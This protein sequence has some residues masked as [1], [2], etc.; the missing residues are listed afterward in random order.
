MENISIVHVLTKCL[1]RMLGQ[2]MLIHPWLCFN[3]YWWINW[4]FWKS[5]EVISHPPLTSLLS[6][7]LRLNLRTHLL[8]HAPVEGNARERQGRRCGCRSAVWQS[9][10]S[11]SS[12]VFPF[13]NCIVVVCEHI[14]QTLYLLNCQ[15]LQHVFQTCVSE[16]NWRACSHRDPLI[17]LFVFFVRHMNQMMKVYFPC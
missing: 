8:F 13:P 5:A 15:N 12:S 9:V 11:Q 1:L 16:S 10:V 14:T 6:W 17:A 4:S 3:F 2:F 7:T